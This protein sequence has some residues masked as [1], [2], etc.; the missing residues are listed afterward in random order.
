MTA[1]D[2]AGP[3]SE[4][5]R[6]ES[7][8]STPTSPGTTTATAGSTSPAGGIQRLRIDDRT[9]DGARR[10][11]ARVVGD[12]AA[13]PRGAAPLPTRRVAG[14]CSSPRAAP[15]AGHAVS[16]ARGPSP[17]GAVGE[18][19]G[20]PDPEPPQHRPAD[21][22]HRPRRSRRGDG[23]VV[24]DGAPRHPASR[25]DADVPR[26]SAGRRSSCRSTGS[27]GGRSPATSRSTCPIVAPGSDH[28][29]A[30]SPP[31]DDFD[32]AV[33]APAVGLGPR[34]RSVTPR[35][36]TERPGLADAAA[37]PTPASTTRPAFVG[38]RQQHLRCRARTLVEVA[39][40]AEAGLA[41][42]MDERHHYEVAVAR[43]RGRRARPHR[44]ARRASSA[45]T[46]GAGRR[47]GA[48]DRDPR[49]SPR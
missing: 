11:D 14:T 40:A 15:S 41:V 10:P 19:P 3:W 49:R 42:R 16:I 22:E 12:R 44:A 18:L 6:V 27:T 20:E 2:P 21:P 38:R 35:R 17:D 43:R 28:A 31:R 26:R 29:G 32:G 8:A 24:V 1:E 34:A 23:R 46:R 45:A 30:R 4:P 25:R 7:P 33:L 39:D 9:G 47:G 5:V 13:V 48:P 36:S 37:A